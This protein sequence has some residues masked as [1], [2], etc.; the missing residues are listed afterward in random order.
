MELSRSST[1]SF[2]LNEE[3][4][5]SIQHA[6]TVLNE[7]AKDSQGELSEMIR[8]D[9]DQIRST[10]ASAKPQVKRAFNEMGEASR[11]QLSKAKEKIT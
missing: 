5:R 3:R 4:T 6:L 1:S 9:L 10:L 11:E 8:K 7:A 2:P